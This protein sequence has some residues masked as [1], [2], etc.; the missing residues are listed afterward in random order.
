MMFPGFGA[1]REQVTVAI[2]MTCSGTSAP[3]LVTTGVPVTLTR[4]GTGAYKVQIKGPLS[5][6]KLKTS[7]VQATTSSATYDAPIAERAYSAGAFTFKTFSF[8]SAT[9]LTGAVNLLLVL[10]N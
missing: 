3:T 8:G 2:S 9:D 5:V 10:G 4:T 6:K 1:E 7:I